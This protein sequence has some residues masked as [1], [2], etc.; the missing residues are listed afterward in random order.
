[1]S[2][3]DEIDKHMAAGRLH[4][5]PPLFSPEGPLREMAVSPDIFANAD[6]SNWPNNRKGERLGKMRATLDRF[7]G[8]G[9]VSI[10]LF[11]KG[12]ASSTFMARIQPVGNE[13]WDIRCTDPRPGIRVLGRFSRKDAFVALVWDFHENLRG[14][15]WG[16]LGGQC[17]QEWTRLFGLLAP[18]QGSKPSDY[19]TGNFTAF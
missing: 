16:D 4:L 13:V 18:H 17:Q 3:S 6:P 15:A 14:K 7:T 9:R 5:L 12:K 10:V 8:N 19:L 11:P 1:M 2:L